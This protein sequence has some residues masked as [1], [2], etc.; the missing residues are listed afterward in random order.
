M[1]CEVE[2][3]EL[4]PSSPQ[5]LIDALDEFEG[6]IVVISHDAR[7]IRQIGCV[8]W[9][10]SEQG[11][12]EVEGDFDDFKAEVLRRVEA[13]VVEIEGKMVAAAE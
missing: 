11:V 10:C 5:A 2:N 7:L 3:L 1:I 8:L 12:W 6:G 13:G 9:E 4:N